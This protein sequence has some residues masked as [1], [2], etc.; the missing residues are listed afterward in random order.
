[1]EI[2]TNIVEITR[3]ALEKVL[4]LQTI[5]EHNVELQTIKTV[6]QSISTETNLNNL[7]RVIHQQILQVMG[8]VSFLIALYH[9]EDSSIEIPYME[10]DNQITSVPAFP[11][12]EGLTSIIVRT[13]QPLLLAEDTVN[14]SRA[15][16]A[17]VTG[18]RPALSWLGVPMLLGGEV[19]GAIIV[20]DLE[21]EHRFDE[22]DMH[23]LTTL[24]S[25][26]AIAINNTRLIE[27]SQ[28]RARRDRQLLEITNKIRFASDAQ[29]VITSTTQE[30][31]K[32]LNLRRAQISL[33]V[34]SSPK[35]NGNESNQEAA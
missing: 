31:A 30:L 22:N 28:T 9:D 16:G 3:I 10:E 11:L 17:I 13:R 35:N 20:Q 27:T 12:G 1:M 15:L 6:S 4:A 23:L 21:N 25:Q 24:A 29:G 7:Y 18:D 8:Q 5:A 19:I 32:A 14:R 33:S 2:F 34:P 26:V